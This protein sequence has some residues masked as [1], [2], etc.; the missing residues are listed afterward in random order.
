[1]LK[2]ESRIY[3]LTSNGEKEIQL[4]VGDIT[5]LPLE[6]KVDVIVIS[7]FP[8]KCLVNYFNNNPCKSYNYYV[9]RIV[10]NIIYE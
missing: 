2:V 3:V 7:A 8:S 4:C 1:M 6:D 5:A 10:C 9:Q